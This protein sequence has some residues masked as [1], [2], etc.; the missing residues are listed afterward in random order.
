MSGADVVGG[1]VRALDEAAS[2]GA[3]V[4]ELRAKAEA[5]LGT[6]FDQRRFHDTLLGMGSVPLPTMEAEMLRWIAAEKARPVPAP[7]PAA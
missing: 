3:V 6:R 2:V 5:E 4:R 1:I 7:A